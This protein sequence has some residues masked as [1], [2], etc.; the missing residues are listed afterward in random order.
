MSLI[1]ITEYA[2]QKI[3]P[4]ALPQATEQYNRVYQDQLNNVLRLYFNRLNTILGQ[5]ETAEG[6]IPPTTVLTVATLPS[7][8][9][10]GT[11]ARAF[12]SDANAT[13][14]ASTVVGGGANK[15]PV[16]SDG[17]NWKIG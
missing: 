5:L 16:Y 12:V 1:I 11:G 7:A 9:T 4:P 8:A 15:V 17:A 6:V 10:S 13:T 3:A 2:P 14:F